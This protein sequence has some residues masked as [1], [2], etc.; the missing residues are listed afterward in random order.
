M[1]KI[2]FT[3]CGLLVFTG[4]ANSNFT[5]N[6]LVSPALDEYDDPAKYYESGFVLTD[7]VSQNVV[8]NLMNNL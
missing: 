7:Q 5:V 3:I 6:T 1:K 2:L 8:D 4:C